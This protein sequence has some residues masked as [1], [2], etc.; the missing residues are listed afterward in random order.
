M[1]NFDVTTT[2]A[3]PA[4]KQSTPS[5]HG[6][7]ITPGAGI[8]P[9]P[10]VKPVQGRYGSQFPKTQVNGFT[11]IAK[12]KPG[13][14]DNIRAAGAR[15]AQQVIDDPYFLAPLALHSLRWVIFD[16]DTR[17]AYIG[18]FDTDFDKYIEDAVMLFNQS[19]VA[20]IFE[21]LEGF[22]EDWRTNPRAFAEFARNHQCE[23]FMEYVE[24]P[25]V[26]AV[27]V[28]KALSLKNAF[29]TM[30]DRMQ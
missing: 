7:E 20:T 22:P 5:L 21:N 18:W 2:A 26:T 8:Y 19:G 23:S 16:N 3:D 24:Y 28:I 13:C 9:D 12:I 27:E 1:R 6:T 4:S 10:N 29:G 25:N 30:L 15:I 17:F 11:V 14:A